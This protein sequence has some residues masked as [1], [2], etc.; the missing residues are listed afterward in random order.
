MR[1][2]EEIEVH[3]LT[4]VALSHLEQTCVG[5]MTATRYS[6]PNTFRNV[7]VG[8]LRKRIDAAV[9]TAVQLA[10]EPLPLF[11]DAAG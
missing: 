2:L 1:E 6:D 3:A 4:D 9:L 5:S 7:K 8:E 11:D 10:G